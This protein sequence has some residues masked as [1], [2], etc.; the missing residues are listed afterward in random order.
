MKDA[1]AMHERHSKDTLKDAFTRH[2][3]CTK[4]LEKDAI[5]MLN[6][7][8][9]AIRAL[10]LPAKPKKTVGMAERPP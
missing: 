5:M 6:Q 1:S 4:G 8:I 7:F 10:L 9:Q 2:L 3:G